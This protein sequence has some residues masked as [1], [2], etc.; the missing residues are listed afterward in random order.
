M[1]KHRK[2]RSLYLSGLPAFTLVIAED[3]LFGA[4]DPDSTQPASVK[5]VTWQETEWPDTPLEHSLGITKIR[6]LN[7]KIKLVFSLLQMPQHIF[8]M[9]SLPANALSA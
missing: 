8:C 2:V 4:A 6:H 1:N 7:K 5:S 9:S 3:N